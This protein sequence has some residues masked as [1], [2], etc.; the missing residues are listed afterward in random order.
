LRRRFTAL[1]NASRDA[2]QRFLAGFGLRLPLVAR[3]RDA[4]AITSV[5]CVGSGAARTLAT[6][7]TQLGVH[8][9]RP[10]LCA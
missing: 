2:K 5:A 3:D 6:N 1:C 9:A 8:I 10:D 7:E 4:H